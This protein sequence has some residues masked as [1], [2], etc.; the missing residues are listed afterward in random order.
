MSHIAAVTLCNEGTHARL[1]S[2]CQVQRDPGQELGPFGLDGAV[3]HAVLR[4]RI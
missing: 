2:A 3:A 1:G 4:A